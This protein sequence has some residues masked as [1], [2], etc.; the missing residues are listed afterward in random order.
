MWGRGVSWGQPRLLFQES[1]V[2]ALSNFWSSPVFVPTAFNAERPNLARN[3]CKDGSRVLG[4]HARH[5]ICT[6]ASRGLSATAAFLFIISGIRH[7]SM[8]NLT[9]VSPGVRP[10][11][12]LSVTFLYCIQMVEDNRQISFSA[13]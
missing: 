6:N 4:G 1:G 13:R 12:C 11:V 3:T 10:S 2:P 9:I 8:I 5:C 7:L